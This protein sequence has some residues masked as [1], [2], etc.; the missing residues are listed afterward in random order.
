LH[1][2]AAVPVVAS[3]YAAIAFADGGFST[4]LIAAG[5]IVIWWVVI[6]G[7]LA[8][9]WRGRKVSREAVA[10]AAVLVGLAAWTALSMGW[11]SDPGRAFAEVVRIASYLGL[12]VL[13]VVASTTTGPRPIL[14][15]LA[16]GLLVVCCVALTTRFLPALGGEDRALFA[17]LP[18]ATGRLSYPIG[19]W[20]GLAACMAALLVLLAWFGA[21]ARLRF[22]RSLSIAL[23]PLPVL[24]IFLASSRGG[25]V[26]A[27]IGLVIL[28]ALVTDRVRLLGGIAAGVLGGVALSVVANASPDLV[29]GLDTDEARTAGIV[30]AA[31]SVAVC[32]G[33]GATRYLGEPRLDALRLPAISARAAA[34]VAAVAAVIAIVVLD[35]VER[36]D[37]FV[38]SPTEVVTRDEGGT[39]LARGGSSGR[40]QFWDTALEAFA[41][42][43]L[44]GIGGGNFELYWNEHPGIPLVINQAHSLY[45]ETLAELGVVGGL[46]LIALLAVL[47]IGA[48]ARLRGAGGGE[49]AVAAAA[50]LGTGLASAALD[51]TWELPAAFA[52]VIV[53][54]AILLQ[55]SAPAE[56]EQPALAAAEPPPPEPPRRDRFGLGIAALV[57]GWVAIWTCAVLLVTE[58]KLDDSRD[59]EERGEYDAAVQDA[60]DAAAVQPWSP[61]PHLREAEAELA[62]DNLE[63]AR[64]AIEDAISRAPDDYR[65]WILAAGI[66]G[67]AGNSAAAER[68]FA[69]A[70]ELVPTPLRTPDEAPG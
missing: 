47:S 52:V 62:R 48:R 49:V 10:V 22:R 40:Y 57:L 8:R 54:A 25:Y 59:A 13:I 63:G 61:E 44:V 7:L 64:A 33:V 39:E 38:D 50:L 29:N 35:P 36:L 19:Y 58:V 30:L 46:L 68:A 5:G 32:A 70:S 17:Q 28:V 18:N 11:A 1:Q 56:E 60:V 4:E 21:S 6:V 15:G 41:S 51:W 27:A 14:S 16:V 53:A 23:I 26:A 37:E 9:W 55:E 42:E 67:R 3:A 65:F 34:A 2:H 31:L 66:E 69:R 12:F 20:N 24:G 43:P 45:L